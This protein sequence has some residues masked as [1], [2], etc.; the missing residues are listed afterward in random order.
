MKGE[1]VRHFMITGVIVPSVTLAL[2][3]ASMLRMPRD[4]IETLFRHDGTGWPLSS[5]FLFF[6]NSPTIVAK[7]ASYSMHPFMLRRL[8]LTGI[9]TSAGN[10][11]KV[12]C[13]P[14]QLLRLTPQ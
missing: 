8:W 10:N 3:L 6:R 12:V 11:T 14:V 4:S 13:E 7:E 9:R 1:R 5:G 2:K